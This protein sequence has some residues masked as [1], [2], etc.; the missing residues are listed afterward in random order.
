MKPLLVNIESPWECFELPE[1][2]EQDYQVTQ[3]RKSDKW[4]FSS[5]SLNYSK[6]ATLLR[7]WCEIHFGSISKSQTV[8]GHNTLQV[9]HAHSPSSQV[10][11]LF[12]S[13]KRPKSESPARS[14]SPRLAPTASPPGVITDSADDN[15]DWCRVWHGMVH[16]SGLGNG[17][18]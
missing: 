3:N 1:N 12:A 7:L 5:P 14:R 8:C 18:I 15:E 4:M 9:S 17:D 16:V 13:M 2:T 6:Y 10:Q 11:D